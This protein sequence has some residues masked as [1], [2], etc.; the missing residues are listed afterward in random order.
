MANPTPFTLSYSYTAFQQSLGDNSFPGTQIDNDLQKV[1]LTTDQIIS[2]LGDVRRTDGGLKNG[3]VTAESLAPSALLTFTSVLAIETALAQTARN[4]A[5]AFAASAEGFKNTAATSA[6]QA[7]AFRNATQEIADNFNPTVFTPTA[8]GFVP[9][10]GGGTSTFLRADGL[11]AVPPSGGGGGGGGSGIVQTIQPGANIAVNNTDSAN[12]V[13]AVT[14]LGALAFKTSIVE[15]DIGASAVTSAKIANDAVTNADLAN[16][17]AGTFK[18]AVSAGDPIDGTGTQATSLLNTFTTTTKGLVPPSTTATTA[19]FLRDDGVFGFVGPATNRLINPGFTNNQRGWASGAALAA[20]VYGVDRFKAGAAGCT[21][22]ITSA[23]GASDQTMTIT[24]GSL[25]QVIESSSL[26]LGTY[27]LSWEGTALG[28]VGGGTYAASPVTLSHT[29][30][31]NETVEWSTGTL[32]RP[33]LHKGGAQMFEARHPSD[34]LRL[35]QRYFRRLLSPPLRGLV[36]AAVGPTHMGMSLAPS[37]RTAPTLT[38]S[39]P[40][41]IVDGNG[42]SGNMTA[43]TTVISSG[44]D[45]INFR[46]TVTGGTG[47]GVANV[48]VVV[49]SGGV[50]DLDAEL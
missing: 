47:F 35:C 24:A 2:S 41:P 39:T 45:F 17:P 11:F 29:G 27:V 34:T 28:R 18:L 46:P 49:T 8:A 37:M 38:V 50:L 36:L 30:V 31:Q 44:P 5:Q 7:M 10:S 48:P 13:V 25:Q 1:K 32:I 43:V 23:A 20:G 4:D 26:E 22:T 14:G 33:R 21:A 16:M 40:I 6:G 3:I 9:A 42:G 15:G 19:T 12:P